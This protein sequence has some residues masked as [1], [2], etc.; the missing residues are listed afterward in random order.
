MSNANN[1]NAIGEYWRVSN[2]MSSMLFQMYVPKRSMFQVQ[3][4]F[5]FSF[6]E[7]LLINCESIEIH[8]IIENDHGIARDS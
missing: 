1:R 4:H 6:Q 3:S 5:N 8:F 2:L 7:L